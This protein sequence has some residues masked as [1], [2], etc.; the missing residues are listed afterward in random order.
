[1]LDD[2]LNNIR[3]V[4]NAIDRR[5]EAESAVASLQSRIDAVRDKTRNL[6]CKPRV[7]CMEWVNPVFCGG[8][9]MKELVEIAGG[10]DNLANHH[11][12]SHRI[13]W[14]RVLAFAPEVIVLTCCGFDLLRCKQE[15]ELLAAF[16]GAL[17]LPAAKTGRIFATDG[18]AYFSRPGPRIV[19]SLE[20]LAH[21]IQP[22]IFPPPALTGAFSC[23]DH[24]RVGTI[25][26]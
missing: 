15:A 3:E 19:D 2:I 21:L 13:E 11:R 12:P 25:R 4:G 17:D 18:S 1:S 9:W 26:P 20:I 8:H 6:A 14:N 10:R 22:G 16:E 23:V 5:S 24:A 7:F